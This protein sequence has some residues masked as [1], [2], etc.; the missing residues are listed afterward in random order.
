MDETATPKELEGK[1]KAA[2]R[3]EEYSEA[4]RIYE[5]AAQAYQAGDDE[6][7]AAEMLNN[8]C[9][10]YLQAE[11]PQEALRSVTGTPQVF[12]AQGDLR[13]YGLALGNLGTALDELGRFE[14]A[15][16]A[17]VQSAEALQ[18]AGE[19]DLRL[20][21]LKSLSSLQMRSGKQI[22]ALITMQSGLEGIEK[23]TIK[24]KAL[25]RILRL[26]FDYLNR[27]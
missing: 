13:N 25:K 2:Y 19:T 10:A 11:A 1:A 12:E 4:A 21:V 22:Q 23:P 17:Y 24:Q 15:A 9:V 7:T 6:V 20:H 26:P 5:A 8:A 16:D 3:R 18:Q 27:G 14:E